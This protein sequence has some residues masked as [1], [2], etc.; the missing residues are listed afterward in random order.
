[1][2]SIR[3]RIIS[4]LLLSLFV[5]D[6][7]SGVY[8]YRDT[9]HE[10]EEIFNAQ[11]AQIA[12]T[13]DRLISDTLVANQQITMITTVPSIGES[14]TQNSFGH[15]YEEKIAYQVW[16][17]E[18]NLLLMSENAPLHP[19]S[20][21]TPGFSRMV[22]GADSWNIFALYSNATKKWIYT[23]QKSEAR[24]ELIALI[25]RD[26]IT[27]M[28]VV[29]VLILFVV[30]IGV[31][32]G[33]RPIEVLS[34]EI[35]NRDGKNLSEITTPIS[36]ELLPIQKGI[37]RLL[38][39]IDEA[40]KKE[41]SFSA[42]LSHELRTPLAAIKVHAQN[43]ELKETVS[44]D[45]RVS[46]A[47]M[48][49]AIDNMSKTIEQLLLLHSIDNRKHEL[50]QE[51]VGLYDLAKEVITLLPTEI[52][53]KN[54]IELVGNNTYILGNRSLTSSLIRNL[55]ENASKYSS[56]SSAIVVSVFEESEKSIL[57]VV[58][59]GPG[60]SSKEKENSIKRH[61]RVSDTQSYGSGLGL[62]IVQKI[63]DLHSG[64]LEF[65]DRENEKGL[66]V[67]VSVK[68]LGAENY[69]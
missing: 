62:T 50:L 42:D 12:R 4:F 17:L 26:Q 56:K 38:K 7:V 54:D 48:N 35:S 16:D 68:S 44:E 63:V 30:I 45:G 20:S 61:Y 47:R 60:M 66:V 11:Q 51:E 28:V 9:Q 1:M 65:K 14:V 15:H 8:I 6:I 40:M 32:M 2:K 18:G 55:I 43:L 3:Y 59:S 22:Y 69:R 31:I 64:S 10:V 25:T 33:I 49:N 19:L 5:I 23:A 27:T 58:D 46:I 52:H 29:N 53:R 34:R 37:N 39:R 57:E 21:T 67:R 41:K 36:K 24:E 13:I